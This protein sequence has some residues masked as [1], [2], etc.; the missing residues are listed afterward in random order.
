MTGTLASA[1]AVLALAST[2]CGYSL[3]A[4]TANMPRGAEHV[5]VRPLQARTTDS[6]AGALVAAA[7]REELARRGVE[8][9]PES[10]ARIEGTVDNTSFVSSATVGAYRF[11]LVVTVRLV[12]N[13]NVVTER[14]PVAEEDYL[15]GQ[16]PLESEGRRRLALRRAAQA[17]ARDIVEGFER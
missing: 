6:E 5:F 12:V 14:R 11:T 15:P 3:A 2:G 4:G 17:I 16:D 7:V 10:P 13:G 9:G 1:F 8:G